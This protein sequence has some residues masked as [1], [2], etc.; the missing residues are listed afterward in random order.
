MPQR[1][2]RDTEEEYEEDC[3]GESADIEVSIIGS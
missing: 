3:E 2:D 1:P